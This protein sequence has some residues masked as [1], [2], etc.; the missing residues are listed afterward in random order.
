MLGSFSPITTRAT[1]PVPS[2]PARTSKQAIVTLDGVGE[3]STTTFGVGE[4]NRIRLI[5]HISFPAFSGAF[6]FGVHLL[7]RFQG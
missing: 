4:G 5:D 3:W 1:P 7:L 6:V 2:S